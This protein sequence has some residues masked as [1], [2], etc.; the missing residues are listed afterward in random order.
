MTAR[1]LTD[2]RA[3]RASCTWSLRALAVALCIGPL[4][5]EALAA[6][7]ILPEAS[8]TF[9]YPVAADQYYL[10]AALE[11]LGLL[12]LGLVHYFSQHDA[13]SVD[14]DLDYDWQSFE[15]KL[16]GSA[17]AF[18]TNYFDTNFITHPG[19]GT[20]YYWA[21]RGN[22]LSALESL[23]Y[24]FA[25]STLWELFGEF[26]EQTSINDLVVTPVT[27]FVLGETTTQLG[28][29]FDRSCKTFA[30]Q[31]AGVVFGPS[32]SLHDAVDGLHP[33][34]DE[35]CDRY[36]LATAGS[37]RLHV[38]AGYAAVTELSEPRDDVAGEFRAGLH[39]GVA[40]LDAMHQPGTGW[41]SFVDGN[42]ATLRTELALGKG[43]LNDLKVNAR[44]VPA[45][46]H[47]RSLRGLGTHLSGSEIVVGALFATEYSQHRYDRPSGKLDKL[48][49]L[50]APGAALLWMLQRGRRL[51]EVE[52]DTA[53]ALAGA[54]TFALAA[55]RVEHPS[56]DLPSV[57][58]AKGY[59]HAVG[60]TLAP[61]VRL[62]TETAEL[63]LDARSDRLYAVRVMDRSSH[64]R[65]HVPIA[66]KRQRARLWLSFGPAT[67]LV[68]TTFWTEVEQRVGTIDSTRT[69]RLE[70]AVG[71]CFGL[72]LE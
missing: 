30:N 55:Y 13:N 48:F 67:G 62:R 32:K 19:A 44:T 11:E 26:R 5:H 69:A 22:R 14:W 12:G 72:G 56:P 71:A 31:L 21:A 58:L 15:R 53:A 37:H 8:R 50:N 54:D 60:F 47:Y 17:Y 36:G 18:D 41:L 9:E 28:A 59:S 70:V 10:R 3:R 23:G 42:V 40:H 1:A 66:E 6:D 39:A 16:D 29:F 4:S 20:L 65:A 51:F 25:S 27:G 35:S 68:Q 64:T 45:G 43:Q 61:R 2:S 46:L 38:W 57:T 34:R 49:V 63:G 7:A 52:L 33:A 24:A